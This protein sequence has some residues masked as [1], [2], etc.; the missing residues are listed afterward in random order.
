MHTVLIRP[1]RVLRGLSTNEENSKLEVRIHG[2]DGSLVTFTQDD[3]AVV[4]HIGP[5]LSD[6][7]F[8]QARK[9]CRRRSA[10]CGNTGPIESCAH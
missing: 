5:G 10:L 3:P 9:N 7:G 2:V 8:F 6:P 1:L 4:E